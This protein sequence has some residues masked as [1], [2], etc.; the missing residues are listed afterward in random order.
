MHPYERRIYIS[1]LSGITVLLLLVAILVTAIIRYHRK[2]SGLHLKDAGSHIGSLDAER[3]RFAADLHADFGQSLAGIKVRLQRI[4]SGNPEVLSTIEFCKDQVDEA[5]KKLRRISV[6][7]IPDAFL[8]Q[9]LE[10]ALQQLLDVMTGDTGITVASA[11]SAPAFN[12]EQSIH[13]YRMVQEMLNNTLRHAGA[14][15]ISMEIQAVK[16]NVIIHF[17]DNGRGFNKDMV[18]REVKGFGLKNIRS[19]ALILNAKVYLTTAPGRG[20]GY[21]IEI[22]IP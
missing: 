22:P 8:Q 19:R 11:Y 21:R 15:R 17:T 16:K 6:S 1:L 14:T 9:G 20:A 13:I 7:M 2:R 5:M 4:R 3:E 18:T 12:M 10:R